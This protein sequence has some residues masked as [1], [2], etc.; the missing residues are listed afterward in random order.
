[1]FNLAPWYYRNL[2][3]DKAIIDKIEYYQVELFDGM[4]YFE[5]NVF[6]NQQL[7]P[8]WL[9]KSEIYK[10][11]SGTGTDKFKNIS[12]HK[13]ISESLERL[14]FFQAIELKQKKYFFDIVPTTNGMAAFPHFLTKY[15]RTNARQEAIERW[16]IHEFNRNHLPVKSQKL[17]Y[18]NL[19]AYE[20]IVPFK[21]VKV[22]I[23]SL[24][25]NDFYTFAF[26]AGVNFEKA[27]DR[28]K[29]ELNRNRTVIK[30]VMD[31]GLAEFNETVDKTL[32][33][34]A[35]EEG[36]QKFQ[37]LVSK[38]PKTIK[39][40][41]PKVLCDLEMVGPWTEYTKVW[42]Y[43]LEDSYFDCSKD[44]TFFMF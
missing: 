41:N 25:E 22:C 38:A 40:D 23:L 36:N 19:V 32:F 20:L 30:K 3:E 1:M 24:Q 29:I 43:L 2:V 13:A 37:E 17:D 35:S 11:C 4:K 33:F 5:S 42:R 31:K 18:P 44:H 6:L 7:V 10:N 39:N 9:S 15:A 21:D 27:I 26:A 28:A 8:N 34:F 12:V 14:A 16:A